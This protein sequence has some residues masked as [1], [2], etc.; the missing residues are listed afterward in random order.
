MKIY[1]NMGKIKTAKIKRKNWIKVLE[2]SD[3]IIY[4]HVRRK[5]LTINYNKKTHLIYFKDNKKNKMLTGMMKPQ[6]E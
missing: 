5:Y 1:N 3:F 2:G 6:W 4:R